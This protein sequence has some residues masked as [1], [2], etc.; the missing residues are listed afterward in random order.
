MY[1]IN[2]YPDKGKYITVESNFTELQYRINSYE[3]LFLMKSLKDANPNWTTVFIPCMFQQQHDRRFNKNESFELKLVCDFINSLNFERVIVFHPHSDVVSALLDNCE[4]VDN[5]KFIEKVLL[6]MKNFENTVLLSADAGGFK[7]LIKLANIIEWEN[8]TYSAS[9][10][11]DAQTHKLTQVLDKQDFEGKDIL[12]VDDICVKGGT[13]LGLA[14][15][16]KERNC[17]KIFLAISHLTVE[18]PNPELF[19]TFDRV[20]TTNSKGIDYK[21]EGS[22]HDRIGFVPENLTIINLFE[23]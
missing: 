8:D 1:K 2:S 9:K 14:K 15:M 11:R 4:V 18:E 13:F 23:S 16:L 6:K 17:G 10:S 22:G 21:V 5:S 20:F 3:D 12:I 19:T 7:P